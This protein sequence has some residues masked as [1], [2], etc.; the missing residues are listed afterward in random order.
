MGPHDYD[1]GWE[2]LYDKTPLLKRLMTLGFHVSP[3]QTADYEKNRS[4]GRFES[5]AFDPEN[6]KPR[7]PTS[8]FLH[9]R[10]DD[11]FWAAR[12]VMAFSDEMIRA[13]VKT[14]RY[15]DPAAEKLLAETLIERRNKIGRAYLPAVN[16]LV[17]FA[18]END[19]TLRFVNAAV[20]A[21]VA[22]SPAGGYTADFAAFDNTTNQ[23]RSIGTAR[24]T[25]GVRIK[26]PAGL[27]TEEGSFLKIQVA[28]VQPQHVSWSVP[29]DAYFKRASGSWTLVGLERK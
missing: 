4:I 9:A 29:I 28:A 22:P 24:T 3:W 19:G 26:A 20:R 25:E 13:I 21:G 16:P 27:P 10:P 23:T 2:H 7:V 1:E 12:R 18:L 8:A 15:S 6:W 5:K 17:D 11:N 14:G